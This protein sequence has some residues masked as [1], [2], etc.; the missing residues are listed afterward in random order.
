MFG[1]LLQGGGRSQE[2][3]GGRRVVSGGGGPWDEVG[4]RRAALGEGAGFVEGDGIDAMGGFEGRGAAEED[5]EF[6]AFAGAD[7]DGGGGSQAE[8]AGAGDNQHG[9]QGEQ[10]VGEGRG[11][12]QQQPKQSGGQGNAAHGRHKYGGHPVRQPLNGSFR[13]LGF[14]D[15]ADDVRQGGVCAD[16]GGAETEKAGAV[17][18]GGID[19]AA[20]GFVNRH[21]FPGKH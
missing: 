10:G 2:L 4:D 17:E 8:G 14:L 18:G 12:P 6:S 15:Q 13:A 7:D 16:P 5:A 9:D 1:I 21:T 3:V 11:R 20:G 19:R